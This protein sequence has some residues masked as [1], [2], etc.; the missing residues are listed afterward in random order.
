MAN[1]TYE[2]QLLPSYTLKPVPQ[3]VPW[4]SDF[5]L[6]LL[7]PV[8]AYWLVSLIF[9]YIDKKDYWSQHRIHTPEEFKQ[10]NRV[11]VGEVLRSILLQQA[12]QTALGL[13]LGYLFVAGDF[14]GREDYDIAIWAGR[15][16]R[17]RE[18]VPWILALLGVD[19]RTMAVN[20]QT[21]ATSMPLTAPTAEKPLVLLRSIVYPHFGDGSTYG[22]TGWEIW[23]AKT[24]Y[25]LLE[26]AARFG[27][28]IFFSDSWQYFWH[29]AM[30]TNKWMFRTS[31]S[32]FSIFPY[33]II[34]LC[35]RN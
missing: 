21:Y 28:A 4:L 19:A 5:H 17:S 12:V 35:E 32:P 13:C 18:A 25:W 1:T 34:A 24:I 15:V 30:H 9:W 23:V 6:S 26:P 31:S 3:L 8:M 2:F 27:V 20:I 11:T 7:L 22:F 16:H 33:A 10:R 14:H 29:R